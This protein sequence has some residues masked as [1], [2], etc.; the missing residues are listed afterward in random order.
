M[1]NIIMME[2]KI[3]K[4][5]FIILTIRMIEVIYQC[6]TNIMW[7]LITIIVMLMNRKGMHVYAPIIK[8]NRRHK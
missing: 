1:C 5:R 4:L 8:T 7:L 6:S 2:R 3:S